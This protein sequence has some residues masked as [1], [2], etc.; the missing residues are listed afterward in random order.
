MDYKMRITKRQLRR[1]IREQ[2]EL[3]SK[4]LPP[5]EPEFVEG[6]D[7]PAGHIVVRDNHDK[8]IIAIAPIVRTDGP[9][10]PFLVRTTDT[11]WKVPFGIVRAIYP[12]V[13]DVFNW[14]DSKENWENLGPGDRGEVGLFE[15]EWI[16]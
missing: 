12:E 6:E 13:E 11:S 4:N 3:A 15:W 7:E 16:K 8:N 10:R 14:V 9:D 1:I 5:Y 2:L